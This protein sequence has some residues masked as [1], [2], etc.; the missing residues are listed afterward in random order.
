[1]FFFSANPSGLLCLLTSETI[2]LFNDT[3]GSLGEDRRANCALLSPI[4]TPIVLCDERA[5]I[6]TLSNKSLLS[7]HCRSRGSSD[8]ARFHLVTVLYGVLLLRAM[9]NLLLL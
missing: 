9:V 8:K 2:S 4:V 5:A 6:R 3:S 7:D 1:M